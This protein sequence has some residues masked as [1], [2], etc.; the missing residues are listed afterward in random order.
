MRHHRALSIISRAARV[1][2]VGVWRAETCLLLLL[3]GCGGKTAPIIER[4]HP[5]DPPDAPRDTTPDVRVSPP[6]LVTG[7]S[8]IREGALEVG[9]D[10]GVQVVRPPLRWIDLEQ[11]IERTGLTRAQAR[12]SD[13]IE[14]FIADHDWSVYDELM[15]EIARRGFIPFPIVGHG[16][17]NKLP[18]YGGVEAVPDVLGPEEYLAR[19]Y[20]VTR[21]TV[22]RYDGDGFLD[23]P[24]D[25][26]VRYW[27][28]ENELNQAL[29]TAVL[30]WRAPRFT[31]ALSSSW[32]DWGYVTD[33]LITLVRAVKD[34]DPSALT[35]MNFHT[36]VHAGLNHFFGQPSWEESIA[37]WTEWIDI[38]GVDAYPNYYRALPVRGDLVGERVRLAAAQGRGKPVVVLETGYP[39]G[40]AERGFSEEQQAMFLEQAFETSQAEGALGILWF[41]SRTSDMHTV[42]ITRE[43]LD[44]LEVLAMSFEQGDGA[45]LIRFALENEPYI[46]TQLRDVLLSVE[47]YWGVVR[48]DGSHKPAWNTFATY[49]AR[50]PADFDFGSN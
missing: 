7:L 15:A 43:D 48:P 26:R 47:E 29:L 18:L 38:V 21:A 28:V 40:P 24:I 19:Q 31:D 37:E 6:P 46:R 50:A 45:T 14:Q 10:L 8:M 23:A 36:D 35:A 2:R 34:A 5:T 33:V 1:Q 30:G 25:V 39:T 11:T 9:S 20:V 12:R 22:E 13:V 3:L 17:A 49:A 27:Q 42:D 32:A 44:A 41:G 16:Y 4:S